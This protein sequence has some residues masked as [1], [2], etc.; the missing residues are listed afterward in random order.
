ML[1][2]ILVVLLFYFPF[3]S[4]THGVVHAVDAP[5]AKFDVVGNTAYLSG[6]IN[7]KTPRQLR[8]L[9]RTH[10]QLSTIVFRKVPGSI[11]DYNNLKAG[12][13]IRSHGLT[14][15]LDDSSEVA[16][17]GTDLFL[18]GCKRIISGRP[19]IG[20][21]AWSGNKL[22]A[23]ALPKN[24]HEHKPYLTYY[25]DMGIDTAFYWYTLRVAPA[26]NIHWMSTGEVDRYGFESPNCN[27]LPWNP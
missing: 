27:P 21:H 23:I 10:P 13:I 8:D 11:S 18:S 9:I 7:S 25:R 5:L 17:G 12:R 20:V 4:C 22:P 16:S 15:M 2:R 3:F 1:F 24:H 6:V 14:T 19:K 26:E